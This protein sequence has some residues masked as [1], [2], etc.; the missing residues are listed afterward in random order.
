VT[1]TALANGN[2]VEVK[3]TRASSTSTT[4]NATRVERAN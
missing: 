2:R 3:G 4:I 1:C